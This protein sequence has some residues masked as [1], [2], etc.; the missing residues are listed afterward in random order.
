MTAPVASS[1]PG[2]DP[3]RYMGRVGG[4]DY[5]PIKWCL[6]WLRDEHPDATIE[7]QLVEHVDNVAIFRAEVRIP[8][9]GCATGYG[10]ES[11]GDFRDYLEKA[12]TKA[13]GR[14]LRALGYGAQFST[15]DELGPESGAQITDIGARRAREEDDELAPDGQIT[16]LRILASKNGMD[17]EALRARAIGE[18][19]CPLESLTRAQA[20]QLREAIR[21]VPK[22]SPSQQQQDG[23]RPTP[24]PGASAKI[25]SAGNDPNTR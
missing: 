24:L 5:L 13:I 6:V 9:G 18:F 12:E 2:F 10:S 4:N 11:A 1:K 7:T 19:G 14:A 8:T 21:A 3:S 22:P 17:D 25:G 20:T 23:T 15:D 16:Y